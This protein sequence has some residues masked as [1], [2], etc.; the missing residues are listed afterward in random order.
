MDFV[1]RHVFDPLPI[2][3]G[4]PFRITFDGHPLTALKLPPTEG[5]P[6]LDVPMRI[7]FKTLSIENIL[8]VFRCL[9]LEEK[10]ILISS[11]QTVLVYV[12][13]SLNALLCPFKWGNIYIPTLPRHLLD[14]IHSPTPFF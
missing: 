6:L 10:I 9:L 11:S 14:Y 4:A 5:L 8:V 13:E 2:P 7:L 12:S 3:A 1:W